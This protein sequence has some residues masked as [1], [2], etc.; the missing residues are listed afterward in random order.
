MDDR[1][2]RTRFPAEQG[3]FIHSV[4][5]GCGAHLLSYSVGTWDNTARQWCCPPIFV[6]RLGWECVA[7]YLP[8]PQHVSMTSFL[9][10]HEHFYLYFTIPQSAFSLF[11]L[12]WKQGLRC[13]DIRMKI[14]KHWFTHSKVNREDTHTDIQRARWYYKHTFIF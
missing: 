8:S 7:L 3:T 1:G 12:F 4:Q 2:I 9:I 11:S 5:T 14:H 10:N 13:H 6:K